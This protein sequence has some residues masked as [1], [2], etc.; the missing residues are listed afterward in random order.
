VCAAR[1]TIAGTATASSRATAAS[2]GPVQVAAGP[3][4][5]VLL[6]D[7]TCNRIRVISG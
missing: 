3:G 1:F 6:S 2:M 5:E 4:G 7:Y